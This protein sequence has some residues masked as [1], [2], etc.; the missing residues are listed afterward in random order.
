[1]SDANMSPSKIGSVDIAQLC[2][3]AQPGAPMDESSR[4]LLDQELE[5]LRVRRE[6][7]GSSRQ[8]STSSRGSRCRAAGFDRP[9]SALACCRRSPK[10]TCSSA[11]TIS[12]PSRAAATSVPR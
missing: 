12:R 3:A 10:R 6:A 7:H 8:R 2:A 1:M 9:A 4:Q 11:S 5:T